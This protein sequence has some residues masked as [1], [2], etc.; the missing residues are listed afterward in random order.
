L[1]TVIVLIFLFAAQKDVLAVGTLAGFVGLDGDERRRVVVV[2]ADGRPLFGHRPDPLV[3]V[4][5]H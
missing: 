5:G 4:G 2:E 1:A 3:A